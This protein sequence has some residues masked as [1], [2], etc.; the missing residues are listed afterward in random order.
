MQ[1]RVN[2][3]T[4]NEIPKFL[5]YNPKNET[6]SIIVIDHDDPSQ[7]VIFPL[8]ISGVTMYLPT[9]TI[10][11]RTWES[12]LYPSLK[13][14]N[15]FLE[16]DSSNKTYEDK[17][18]DMTYFRG[19]VIHSHLTATAPTL[20]INS[21]SSTTLDAA[22]LTDDYNFAYVL[23]SHVNVSIYE[24]TSNSNAGTIKSKEG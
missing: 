15:E 24:L 5:A 7:Q 3:L 16:W 23:E 21:M 10:T 12:S 4:I 9:Q 13:L 20:V 8:D 18:N 1:A 11:K 19:N 17:E 22:A 14:K 6:Q 2:D